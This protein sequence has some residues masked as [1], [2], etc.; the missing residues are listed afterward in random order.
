M[1]INGVILDKHSFD[2][3]DVDLSAL[4]KSNLFWTEHGSTQPHETIARIQNAEI[5]VTNKVRLDGEAIASTEKLR[6]VLIAATGTDNVDLEACKKR[7]I[8]V[9]NATGYATPSVAQH[10]FTLIL[11]LTTSLVR[12]HQLVRDDHWQKSDVFCLIDYPIKELAGKTMGIIG[13]GV[14]GKKVA[15]IATAFEMNVLTWERPNSAPPAD[16]SGK[17]IPRIPL[18]DLLKSSDVLS[19]HCPLTTQTHSLISNREL[20]LMKKSA[21]LINTA[22][23]AI[24]DSD[25]LIHALKT[26]EIA[27]AGVDVLHREPPTN[28]H[29][30]IANRLPNLIVTPHN[31]WASIE[32]RQRLVDQIAV[33]LDAWIDGKP[34]N[35]VNS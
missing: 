1:T 33:T 20:R 11:N 5:L 34:R 18:D 4:A 31:A 17:G 12:Y 13:L 27:G 2:Q 16:P 6:L 7:G 29:P 24:V 32:S 10:V 14:L 26:G 3:E 15:D 22:R 30:L 21:F 28:D 8:V 25:A 9:C 35:V 19:I 23:G